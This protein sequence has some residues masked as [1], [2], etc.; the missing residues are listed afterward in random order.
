MWNPESDEAHGEG[1]GEKV[2]WVPWVYPI[3]FILA[4]VTV[5][6]LLN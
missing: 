2:W 5:L 6:L 4:G 3:G 1:P